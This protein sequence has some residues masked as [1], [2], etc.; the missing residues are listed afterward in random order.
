MR[1]HFYEVGKEQ[2]YISE[3]DK[4]TLGA[5]SNYYIDYTDVNFN[6]NVQQV[7]TNEMKY[8]LSVNGA[9]NELCYYRDMGKETPEW[10]YTKFTIPNDETKL[11]QI[12][13]YGVFVRRP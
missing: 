6:D 11:H 7:V 5:I 10:K 1:Y 3:T 8:Y 13:A 2:Y 12:A 9:A 4:V